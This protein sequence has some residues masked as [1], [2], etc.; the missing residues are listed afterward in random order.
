ML[1]RNYIYTQYH[2]LGYNKEL[3][4]AGTTVVTANY[5]DNASPCNMDK[6]CNNK[7]D[8]QHHL[9]GETVMVTPPPLSKN[10]LPLVGKGIGLFGYNGGTPNGEV[11]NGGSSSIDPKVSTIPLFI[12]SS[13]CIQ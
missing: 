5:I 2:N 10:V 12:L 4:A 6:V 13:T 11:V 1:F 8:D 9:N 7:M 3:M